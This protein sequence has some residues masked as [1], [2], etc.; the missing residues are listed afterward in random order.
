MTNGCV[1]RTDLDSL[2]ATVRDFTATV[3]HLN[4]CTPPRLEEPAP[5]LPPTC[6]YP[7]TIPTGSITAVVRQGLRFVPEQGNLKWVGAETWEGNIGGGRGHHLR[8]WVHKR[9]GWT[10]DNQFYATWRLEVSSRSASPPIVYE[11]TEL[12]N[13]ERWMHECPPSF[14]TG[15]ATTWH[16]VRHAYSLLSMTLGPVPGAA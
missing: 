11:H 5:E 3:V 13:E 7:A 6:G 1:R 15:S 10:G 9:V 8:L 14:N 12:L 2:V 16:H 4:A